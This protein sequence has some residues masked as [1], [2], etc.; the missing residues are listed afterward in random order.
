MDKNRARQLTE[1]VAGFVRER[2]IPAE[3]EYFAA[4]EKD[5]WSIPPMIELLKAEARG[6]GLWN[7]FMP[8]SEWGQ[9]LTNAQYAPMCELMGRS[10]IGAEIFNCSAPDTGNMELLARY[11]SKEQKQNWLLPLLDGRIR[12]AYVMTEPGVAS[13]DAT[14]IATRIERVASGYK[15]SGTKWW[16]SGMGDPRCQLLLVLGL[17]NPEASGMHNRHSVLIVPRNAPGI[18]VNRMLSVFGYDNAPHGH[19]EMVFDDVIVPAENLV[20]GEGR[21]FEMAQGRL[22]PGRVHHCMRL[23]GLAERAFETMCARLVSRT[24]FGKTLAEQSVWQERIADARISIDQSRLLTLHAAETM[25]NDGNKAARKQIAMIKVAATNMACQVCDMAIQ[26]HGAAGV[27]PDSGIAYAY[28]QARALRFADG[29]DE[30][31]RRQI[32]R[33]ELKGHLD[34]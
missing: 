14:N 29:P 30:V 33:L 28:A 7:L 12:S 6:L 20:L 9:G 32:A 2:I 4:L 10:P 31:H 15:V 5:R 1:M 27:G 24:A 25:D 19:A 11:G 26:A 34:A 17:S 18:R 21:G 22:G 8:D 13:S 16:I 23:I 3:A